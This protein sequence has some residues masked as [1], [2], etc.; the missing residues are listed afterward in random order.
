MHALG[1]VADYDHFATAGTDAPVPADLARI[2]AP[3][4]LFVGALNELKVDAELLGALAEAE[5]GLSVVLVGPVTE[6]GPGARRELDALVRRPNV[7][8]LGGRPYAEL[9][10]YL[11]GADVG[12]VPYLANRYTAGVFP[13]KVYE[14]LAAGLPVVAAGLPEL[15]GAEGAALASGRDEFVNA[16]RAA[17]A[18]PDRR[19]RGGAS[20]AVTPGRRARPRW[21]GWR[22]RRSRAEPGGAAREDRCWPPSARY[23]DTFGGSER[24]ARETAWRLAGRGH[25]VIVWTL[26]NRVAEPPSAERDGHLLVAA[27][28]ACGGGWCR[29]RCRCSASGCTPG[30]TRGGPTW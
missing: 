19:R 3:R 9:P 2:P 10:G 4:A 7:H 13:M 16:V 18:D 14:Y 21:T 26:R 15:A 17:L 28:A 11:A 6:A 20:P 24:V 5:P 8:A 23:P 12:L 22:G 30:G 25:Q 1:N 27:T 29:A